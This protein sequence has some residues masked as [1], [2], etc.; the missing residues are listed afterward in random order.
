MRRG[1]SLKLGVLAVLVF[2][3]CVCIAAAPGRAAS[4]TASGPEAASDA[5]LAGP[6]PDRQPAPALISGSFVQPWFFENWTAARWDAALS[7]LKRAGAADHIIIQ[8]TVDS[9]A[10]RAWYATRLRGF[11]AAVSG[12]DPVAVCLGQ[13]QKAGIKVWLGLNWNEDWWQK[14]ADD[15]VWLDREF[16]T[17]ATLALDLYRCYK[18]D[19]D[20]TIAGFYI[21]L[22]VDNE[23]FSRASSAALMRDNYAALCSLVHTETGKPLM[24]SPFVSDRA[25]M[26]PAAW[27]ELWTGILKTA[28][29]DVINMQD[30]CGASDEGAGTHTTPATVGR[31]FAAMRNAVDTARPGTELWSDLETFD[32]DAGDSCVPVRDPGRIQKQMEAEAPYVSRFSS[33]SLIQY[34]LNGRD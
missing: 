17:A 4:G 30:G 34:Q 28:A 20:E 15:K 31:W 27:Q 11:S 6:A 3:S 32:M 9:R 2:G 1:A 19:F 16:A 8:W 29:I 10:K 13:A 14:Y 22:E 23:N 33:Y 5:Q 21:P 18:S 24:I 12:A 26:N 7:A 25:L